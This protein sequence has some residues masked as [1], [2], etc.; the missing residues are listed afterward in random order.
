MPAAKAI[1]CDVPRPRTGRNTGFV[2]SK[3]RQD[4]TLADGG[5]AAFLA[6]V[7]RHRDEL[8]RFS[9]SVRTVLCEGCLLS[10]DPG[11]DF[12]VA[13]CDSVSSLRLSASE[14]KRKQTGKK[15][16]VRIGEPRAAAAGLHLA[17]QAGVGRNT[18]P[19]PRRY[20][21]RRPRNSTSSCRSANRYWTPS[22]P[23][24]RTGA[25]ASDGVRQW[26]RMCRR[27]SYS[28]W[29]SVVASMQCCGVTGYRRSSLAHSAA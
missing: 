18:P 22:A 4:W 13:R 3:H 7:R 21:R 12:L 24:L 23:R 17:Q 20:C 11:P 28:R 27:S 10:C 15:R 1:V 26:R 8:V 5:S 6:V 14:S 9:Q 25:S 16:H 2:K 19:R 29:I